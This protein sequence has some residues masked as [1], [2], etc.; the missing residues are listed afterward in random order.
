MLVELLE[1]CCEEWSHRV[2]QTVFSLFELFYEGFGLL[3]DKSLVAWSWRTELKV[4][5]LFVPRYML[6]WDFNWVS[7]LSMAVCNP[8]FFELWP[9]RNQ[10][11][12]KLSFDLI[13]TIIG[14]IKLI[15]NASLWFGN[16][17]F[18]GTTL[19]NLPDDQIFEFVYNLV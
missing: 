13:N 11:F 2:L 15:I 5:W 1:N 7:V 9:D 10:V 19:N 8:P 17:N 4:L 12:F 3:G 14:A 6:F 18:R 16:L